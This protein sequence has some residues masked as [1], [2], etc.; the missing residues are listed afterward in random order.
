MTSKAEVLF[1]SIVIVLFAVFLVILQQYSENGRYVFSEGSGEIVSY[2][3]V[4]DTRTGVLFG[5][6]ASSLTN[7][8][9][10]KFDFK[11]QKIWFSS[12]Q[13]ID[14]REMPKAK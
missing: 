13:E 14:L 9:C 10:Y 4:F 6:K 5:I 7:R 11:A 8:S 2:G 1:R 3:Q 12:C